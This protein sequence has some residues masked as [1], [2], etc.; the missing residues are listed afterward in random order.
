MKTDL[1][2]QPIIPELRRL[3]QEKDTGVLIAEPGAGKTTVVPLALL[4]GAMGCRKAITD[5][6]APQTRCS[7]GSCT[8]GSFTW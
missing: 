8:N 6:G 2:I 1:P 7:L 4:Q 3:F 5:A